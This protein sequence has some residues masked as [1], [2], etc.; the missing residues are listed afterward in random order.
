[1]CIDSPEQLEG[2]RMIGGIVA[3]ALQV[4]REA[5]RPGVTT[6]EVNE[7][8]GKELARRGAEPA[9]LLVTAA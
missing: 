1:M 9:P 5:V 7:V 4:M 8:A 6:A 2:M 3:R